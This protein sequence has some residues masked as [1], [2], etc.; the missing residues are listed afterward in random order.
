MQPLLKMICWSRASGTMSW[1]PRY[2]SVMAVHGTVKWRYASSG[3]GPVGG[4]DAPKRLKLN[5]G[6]HF[7]IQY[8]ESI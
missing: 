5:N 2:R 4:L 3:Y 1:R 8:G 6:G 7:L